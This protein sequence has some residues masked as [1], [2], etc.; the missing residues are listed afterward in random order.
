LNNV[1]TSRILP[2]KGI[3][4][5]FGVALLQQAK[6]DIEIDAPVANTQISQTFVN[7]IEDIIEAVYYFIT[8]L[9]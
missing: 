6:I 8:R 5:M 3:T 4:P 7:Q 1:Q 9:D 2:I